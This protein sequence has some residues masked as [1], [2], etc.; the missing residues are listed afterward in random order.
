MSKEL[1]EKFMNDE[2]DDRLYYFTQKMSQDDVEIGSSFAFNMV[3]AC[4]GEYLDWF[5]IHEVLAPVPDYDQF[6]EL[7]EKVEQL[8][9]DNKYLK[10]GIETRD[11]QIEQLV[12][13]LEIST[14]ALKKINRK[15][16]FTVAQDVVYKA[17]KEMK[18]LK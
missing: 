14:K 7:T 2:L 18:G 9:E 3:R 5:L 15:Y 6:V 1:T 12:K 4:D 11:K 16:R 10:S 17:L 8:K 13:Q